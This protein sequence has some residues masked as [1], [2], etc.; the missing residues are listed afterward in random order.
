MLIFIE[1]GIGRIVSPIYRTNGAFLHRKIKTY[2]PDK[3]YQRDADDPNIP[4][5]KD[6]QGWIDYKIRQAYVERKRQPISEVYPGYYLNVCGRPSP[7]LEVQ[8]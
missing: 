3:V 2:L 4:H 1:D 6:Y 5:F 8:S 7:F